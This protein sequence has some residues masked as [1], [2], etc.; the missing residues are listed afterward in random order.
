MFSIFFRRYVV[1]S[2]F[3]GLSSMK[4]CAGTMG[5]APGFDGFS[6]GL[7]AGYVNTNSSK[8]TDVSMVSP[9]PSVTEYFRGDDIKSSLSPVVNASYFY[10]L[11]HAWLV[12]LKGLYKYLGVQHSKIAWSGTFQNGTYQQADFHT[13]I[14]Q[15][16]FLTAE[17]AYEFVPNWMVYLGFGPAVTGVKNELRGNLLESTALNFQYT[18]KSS[19]K[20]LWGGAGQ[21]GFEYLLPHRFAIDISYNL[22][23]SPTTDISPIYFRTNSTN[24][25]SKFLGQIQ[26]LEQ[27][28][29]LTV[30][31]YF[32]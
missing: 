7:G 5:G 1:F 2:I 13:N 22:I 30:N 28:L 26:L 24:Y 27:G 6:A 23:V 18:E 14:I 17:A 4:L 15:E 21:L 25:Y 12:G 32:S 11:D 19:R 8:W 10:T 20:T 3:L 29:N 16:F 31:K 9:F